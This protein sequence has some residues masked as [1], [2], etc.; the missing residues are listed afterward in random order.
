[1]AGPDYDACSLIYKAP[2]CTWEHAGAIPA[3]HQPN[4]KALHQAYTA[5]NPHWLCET[6]SSARYDVY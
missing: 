1:M 4:T 2:D 5:S 3:K 6:G